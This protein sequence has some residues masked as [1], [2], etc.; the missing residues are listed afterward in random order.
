MASPVR[1]SR[2]LPAKGKTAA[3]GTASEGPLYTL[4]VFALIL[5]GVV[6]QTTVTP[7]LT[8]LGA[9][10]DSTL[11]LVVCVALLRGPV[12][13]AVVG[14]VTG[15]LLDV[16]LMQTMGISSFLY[17]LAGYAAGRYAEGVDTESWIPPMITV[18]LATLLVQFLNAVIM[19]LLGIE[20][21]ASFVLIRIVL[22]TAFLGALLAAPVF[23]LT[24]W[25]IGGDRSGALFVEQ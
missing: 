8:V 21:S 3:P 19:F 1:R 6:I 20:V 23:I 13:G 9:K 4:R 7:Y 25:W 10:P 12:W 17:T 2:I 14:F 15:L 11:V 16:S 24:R 18:F 22:P 5:L